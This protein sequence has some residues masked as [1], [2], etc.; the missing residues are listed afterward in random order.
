LSQ[1]LSVLPITF[2]AAVAV[3]QH[4][5]PSFPSYLVDI[6][7]R[8]VTLPIKQ[9]VQGEQLKPGIIY[10]A[11][12]DN[13]LIVNSDGTLS[14]TQTPLVHY[15]RPSADVLFQSAAGSIGARLIAVIL[16][17]TG[18]DG[19]KGVQA[20]KAA[21]GRV[22]VQDKATSAFYG[23]PEAAILTGSVDWILPLDAIPQALERLATTG[24]YSV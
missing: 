13:H 21:G 2:P 10:V 16:T 20:V 4:L 5:S 11:P 6:L 12:P 23:M 14:L 18:S 17:G 15:V 22:I 24:D 1:V 8:R 3:V 19:A 7:Q 9:A